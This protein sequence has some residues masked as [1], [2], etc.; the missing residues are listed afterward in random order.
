LSFLKANHFQKLTKQDQVQEK[1][2]PKSLVAKIIH[3]LY[4]AFK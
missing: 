4:I 2:L 1:L 3:V